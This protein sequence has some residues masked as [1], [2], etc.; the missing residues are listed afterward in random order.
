M[1]DCKIKIEERLIDY[2]KQLPK[3]I[4]KIKKFVDEMTYEPE[5]KPKVVANEIPGG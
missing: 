3:F 5:E 4:D 1:D 2:E